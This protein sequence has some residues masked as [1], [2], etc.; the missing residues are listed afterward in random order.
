M[1]HIRIKK[2]LDIPISGGPVQ[3]VRPGRDV[4]RVAL[5]GNDSFGIRPSLA[6]GEGDR[7]KVGQAL[8]TDKNNPEVVYTS[9]GC[10]TV[11]E[12]NRGA[13]RRF[14][15]LVI[16]VDGD[17]DIAFL[18]HPGDDPQTLTA[19]AVQATLI[20]SGLWTSL[21]TRP[22][23][24]IPAVAAPPASLFVTAIDTE[25]LAADPLV[26]IALAAADFRRGLQIL[27]RLAA[28]PIHL[29]SAQPIDGIDDI[30]DLHSWLFSGP[31]PAGLASTHIHF[32]DPVHEHKTVWQIGYQDVIAIGHLFRTGRLQTERIIAL[33]GPAISKPGLV[34]TRIGASITELCRDETGDAPCRLISGS[35]LSGR[36]MAA[37]VDFLGR[38]HN[39]VSAVREDSGRSLFNWLMPGRDRFSLK[40]VFL[41]AL[42]GRKPLPMITATWGGRRAIFPIG[43]Y[44]QVMPLDIIATS[45]LRSIAV[46]DSEKAQ[47]LGCL[48]LIEEDL[49]LCSFVCPGKND[50]GPMLRQLLTTIESGG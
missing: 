4:G 24:R 37:P 36:A 3:N 32:I 45:L 18:D 30:D 1:N 47:E 29:C 10:G 26:I 38:Y 25:P 20:A 6:V 17:D 42:L 9:P 19:A 31:H 28:C 13:K 8:F 40:P 27:R 44:E 35:V 41:S 48:E 11:V 43:S 12:I 16:A 21:R 15:S 7:V 46:Q 14:Q 34:T 23:G 2:G 5:L 33:A 49:A 39:Q 50:F 22:F